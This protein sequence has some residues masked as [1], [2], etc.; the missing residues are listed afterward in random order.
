MDGKP[1]PDATLKPRVLSRTKF[2]EIKERM[3]Q[4]EIVIKQ[5][6]RKCE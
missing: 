5:N 1:P 2:T 6:D 4:L 3:Q